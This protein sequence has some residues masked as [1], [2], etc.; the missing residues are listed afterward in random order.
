MSL[1]LGSS[2]FKTFLIAA[3]EGIPRR[4]PPNP[5]GQLGALQLL[6]A[7]LFGARGV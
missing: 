3:L 6:S 5:V 2:L 1:C 4:P 7:A